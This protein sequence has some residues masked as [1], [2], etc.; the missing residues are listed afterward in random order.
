M[1]SSHCSRVEQFSRV[2][3]KGEVNWTVCRVHARTRSCS[4]CQGSVGHGVHSCSSLAMSVQWAPQ[5]VWEPRSRKY[6][7]KINMHLPDA[8]GYVE[9]RYSHV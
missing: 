3:R 5:V 2:E 8:F 6:E 9:V 4:P 1:L 7:G